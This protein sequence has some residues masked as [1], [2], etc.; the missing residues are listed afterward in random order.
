[1]SIETHIK[2]LRTKHDE[3]DVKIHNAYLHHLPTADLKK[4]RLFLKDEI[5]SLRHKRAA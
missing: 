4:Q 3:L 5:S 1:M 2:S